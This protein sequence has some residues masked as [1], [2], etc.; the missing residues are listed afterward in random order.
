[1]IEAMKKIFAFGIGM[2]VSFMSYGQETTTVY[3]QDGDAAFQEAQFIK[4]VYSEEGILLSRGTFQDNQRHGEWMAFDGQG[5]ELARG[6][7]KNGLKHGDW[8]I[9]SRDGQRTFHITYNN[10]KVVKHAVIESGTVIASG[11]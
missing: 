1:M 6:H 11:N 5:R 2:L 9:N 8:V 10:N 7:Y 3:T 4:S